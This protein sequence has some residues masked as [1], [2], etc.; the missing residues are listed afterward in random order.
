MLHAERHSIKYSAVET[1][2]ITPESLEEAAKEQNLEFKQG[3]ILLVRSGYTKWYNEM[4]DTAERDRITGG[5]STCVGVTGTSDSIAW[6]WD[7]H[8][9][10]VAGDYPT[11]ESLP[12]P[13]SGLR[14]SRDDS[15]RRICLLATFSFS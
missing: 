10:A 13:K 12:P 15:S 4:K 5:G 8:F 9:E 1:H 14:T 7:H 3:D 2:T 6:V 11:W